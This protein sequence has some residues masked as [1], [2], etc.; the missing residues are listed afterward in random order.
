VITAIDHQVAASL[1]AALETFGWIP[2]AR[3]QREPDATL[4]LSGT[5]FA[6]FNNVLAANL[7]DDAAD[8]R[9]PELM[10]H[11]LP[12]NAPLTWWVTT[13]ARPPDLAARLERMGLVRQEPEF[14]M[15]ID[16]HREIEEVRLPDGV[17]LETVHRPEQL[18]G[19]L[20][21]MHAAYGWPERE[22]ADVIRSMYRAGLA[23]PPDRRAIRHFLVTDHG[24]PV[25]SSSLFTA[26]GS[27]FVTNIGTIPGARGRGLGTAATNAT[28]RLAQ[29]LG[30]SVAT[31]TASVDGRSV[32][33]RIG[34]EEAGVV[35]RWVATAADVR[36][37]V[38]TRDRTR[39]RAP[40]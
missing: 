4:V 28:L 24:T 26:D 12:D 7:P 25:A 8:D 37:A 17:L 18:D 21:V 13:T 34:F 39:N 11:F 9:I 38:A 6:A 36:R 19:W 31:L 23:E 3:V 14:A 1:W 10:A 30:R 20:G 29:D 22:K 15:A 32:Y 40:A 16:L 5:Q 33:R 27:A 35:D 2:G